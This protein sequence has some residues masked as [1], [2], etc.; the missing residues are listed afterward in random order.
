MKWSDEY[1]TGVEKI[2]HQHKMIFKMAEDFRAALD[3]GH[4]GGVVYGGLLQ[5]LELYVRGHFRFEEEC[6]E[7][8]HCPAALENHEAHVKFAEALA[9]FRKRYD[10]NGF[11]VGDAR[12]LVD[13]IDGWLVNHICRIDVRLKDSVK[14]S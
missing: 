8:Y 1:G 3:E 14:N 6:M 4:G 11:A 7:R 13:T 9:G 10:A 12:S 2:D 5:S